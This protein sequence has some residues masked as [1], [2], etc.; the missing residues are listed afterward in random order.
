MQLIKL[1]LA[2]IIKAADRLHNLR[3]MPDDRSFIEGYIKDTEEYILPCLEYI[4]LGQGNK[5][6]KLSDT[7]TSLLCS[8]IKNLKSRYSLL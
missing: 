5:I 1:P 8:E 3:T 6:R 7:A 4:N 2:V